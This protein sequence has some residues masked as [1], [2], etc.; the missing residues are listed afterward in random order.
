MNLKKLQKFY[1]RASFKSNNATDINTIKINFKTKFNFRISLNNEEL[2]KEKHKAFGN[3]SKIDIEKLCQKISTDDIDLKINVIDIFYE[4]K[5]KK[6]NIE[7]REEKVYILT[8]ELMKNKLKDPNIQNYFIDITYKIIPKHF[9]NYKLMTI[10][11]VNKV[12]NNTYI[13]CLILLKYEDTI[14]FTKIFKYLNDMFLFNPAVINIDYSA[15]LTRAL[16]TDNIFKKQPIIIHC[17]FHFVQAIVK[18]MKSNKIIIHKISK[19]SFE[20]LKNIELICF[21]PSNYINS[22]AK[23]LK[24]HLKNDKEIKLYEY[25]NKN[26]ISKTP[27]YF[28]YYELFNNDLLEEGIPH[29]YTTNN[30]AESLHSKLTLYLP[31]KKITNNNIISMRNVILNYETKINTIKRKDYITKSLICKAKT[32]Q[33]NKYKWLSY[34]DI[35]EL[36]KKTINEENKDININIVEELIKSINNINLDNENSNN[37]NEEEMLINNENHNNS[38]EENE[39]SSDSEYGYNIKNNSKLIDGISEEENLSLI[40]LKRKLKKNMD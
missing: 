35:V 9:R 34:D 19:Y 3:I 15:S 2:T 40:F 12:T 27:S 30:I 16:K 24:Q 20:I 18:N 31:N 7:K 5:T 32:L 6:E 17:F 26:W 23:F 1:T 21:I 11:G 25:L 8:T 4:Y 37:N 36:E 39:I 13:C 10:T 29:F 14:S 22:Y 38:I 28:N 33:K